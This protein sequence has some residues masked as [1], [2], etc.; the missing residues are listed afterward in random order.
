M[1]RLNAFSLL[2]AGAL[3]ATA[4][5]ALAGND[6][7]GGF[8]DL[9]FPLATEDC[10]DE[11][12][13]VEDINVHAAEE[14]VRRQ[15]VDADEDD[16][17]LAI[18]LNNNGVGDVD[19]EDITDVDIFQK[20]RVSASQDTDFDRETVF[21]ALALGV[22]DGGGDLD[23][24][25]C[26]SDLERSESQRVHFTRD[27][28]LDE[29]DVLLAIALSNANGGGDVEFGQIADIEERVFAEDDLNQN[30]DIQQDD[31]FLALALGA[32]S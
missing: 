8:H 2:L 25:A 19:W 9:E 20:A 3:L 28:D 24:L 29:D 27:V 10:A 22:H 30:V 21:S 12:A 11:V 16:I 14:A 31:A 15:H 7:N 4:A 6:F 26:V 18:A 23:A 13:G 5:P 1:N 17:L 32:G